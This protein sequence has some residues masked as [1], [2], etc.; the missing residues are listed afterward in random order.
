MPGGGDEFGIRK[1]LLG[2]E[3]KV[4]VRVCGIGVQVTLGRG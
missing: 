3:F 2:P 4:F 1:W